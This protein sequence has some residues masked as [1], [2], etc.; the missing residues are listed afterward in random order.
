MTENQIIYSTKNFD[1]EVPKR[2]FVS[3]EEGGHLR[4]MS[5]ITVSDRTKLSAKLAIEYTKLSMMVGE[6]LKLGL[7]KR[8]VEIGIVNYQEMGNWSVYKAGGPIM[9]M[10]IFGRSKHA[11]V[12]QYGEAVKLPKRE[13]GFYDKFICLDSNDISEIKLALDQLAKSPKYLDF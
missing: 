1:V 9:H 4:I 10:H 3:R 6:A 2:P 8:D 13:T 7:A 12:Q 5:K 11:T